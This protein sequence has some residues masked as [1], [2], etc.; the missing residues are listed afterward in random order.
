MKHRSSSSFLTVIIGGHWSRKGV[1]GCAALKTPISRLFCSSQWSHFKQKCQFTTP[2]W[3]NL[4]ILASTASIFAQILAHKPQLWKFSAHKPPNLEIFSSQ[5]PRQI[6]VR[7]P[8][9]SEIR[10]AHPYLKKVECPPQGDNPLDQ[11]LGKFSQLKRYRRFGDLIYV[12]IEPRVNVYCQVTSCT[13]NLG[14][15][16]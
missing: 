16:N 5:A 9:I 2:F 14:V 4:E 10:A 15:T 6:S 7:K 13:G 3:E 12:S 11:E 1:W 8:H